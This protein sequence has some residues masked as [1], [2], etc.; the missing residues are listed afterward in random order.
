MRVYLS[1]CVYN[2]VRRVAPIAAYEEYV[3]VV[4]L[5][6]FLYRYA[7]KIVRCAE[8]GGA[9]HRDKNTSALV[10]LG[11]AINCVCVCV[12]LLTLL[13]SYLF[14]ML[15]LHRDPR[16]RSR[17]SCGELCVSIG[18]LMRTHFFRYIVCDNFIVI[19]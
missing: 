12:P 14:A 1:R 18:D 4:L 5:K 9:A 3:V 19:N 15:R 13:I 7:R 6:H 2:I 17:R 11:S 16:A 8:R 10:Q